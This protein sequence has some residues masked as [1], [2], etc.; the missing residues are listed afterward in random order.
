MYDNKA[1][2]DNIYKQ[3]NAEEVSWFQPKPGLSLELISKT[4]IA[5]A[6]PVIDVG[7]GY[8]QLVDYLYDDGYSKLAV[9]DI[10]A[11][12]LSLTR[13]R[14]GDKALQIDWFVQDI[15][16]FKT[17][18]T[19]ALWHDRAVFHFLTRRADR[20]QYVNVLKRS[21]KNNGHL[22]IAAFAI[23]GPEKCSGL[24]IVQYDSE[25]LQSELGD[26]FVLVGQQSE[27]HIT[28]SNVEQQFTYYRFMHNLK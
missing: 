12:A 16:Q 5:P 28:P 17:D 23:G 1:H 25:K 10:S 26:N 6:E 21:L 27:V 2:W 15:L 7:G 3:K 14:L 13:Q 9:L 4:N 11:N 8:S 24:D 19:F 20:E 18:Q 22:I